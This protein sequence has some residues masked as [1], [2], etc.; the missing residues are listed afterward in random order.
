[1][2]TN[3]KQSIA[4]LL[5]AGAMTIPFVFAA[6]EPENVHNVSAVSKNATTLTISWDEAKDY[7]GNDVDHY[8]IYYG[9]ASVQG[10]DAP[11]Y[12]VEVDTP[13]N[14]NTYD[15]AGLE[16]DTT[17]YLSVTAIDSSDVESLEYSIEA[18]GTPMAAT[19]EGS[20]E[21]TTAPIVLNVVAIDT[22][23]VLVGFSE[24]VKLPELLAE[25]AF[26]I[27]EQINPSHVLEVLSAAQYADDPEGKT[28]ILE[29]TDQ[30]KNVNYI[31]TASVAI[32]DL[33]GNPIVS[34]STDSGLF[35]GTDQVPGEVMAEEE[36]PV[37]EPV[38]EEPVVE[39]PSIED[40]L[41]TT[42]EGQGGAAEEADVTPPEDITNLVLSFKEQLEK[43]VI[44]MNWTASLNTAKDLVDQI[45]Y[46]SM[47]RGIT[48]NAGNSLGPI[49][50]SHQVPNLEGGK[51]YTFKVTTKD[52]AGNESVGVVKS[53][54]LPQTGFGAG[55]LVFTSAAAAY[56][57]LRRKKRKDIF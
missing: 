55:I 9:T 6:N 52:A 41:G 39:E 51:E 25:A 15:L 56:Q 1:M 30:T 14:A 54:R 29:T 26:T 16:T 35:L 47:D 28:V 37:E 22:N 31:M 20:G 27:T 13:D 48:Y 10:G 17:Y 32:T 34:G 23:H 43:F 3:T 49:V 12:E 57:A 18:S 36:P 21:D 38:V 2:K 11:S 45:L 44:T 42:E 19:E 53:I 46:M 5:L 4:A 40:L 7:Q 8:R 24:P 33:A 50:T